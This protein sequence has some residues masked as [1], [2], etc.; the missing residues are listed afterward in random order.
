MKWDEGGSA[1]S[2]GDL[3]TA[4]AVFGMREGT[5]SCWGEK[6]A[7][8]RCATCLRQ[9]GFG[10]RGKARSGLEARSGLG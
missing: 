10:M 9:S 5:I 3:P 1:M 8:C 7:R 6:K 2:L 4:I